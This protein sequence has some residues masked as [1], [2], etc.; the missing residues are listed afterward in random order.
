MHSRRVLR[1]EI[2]PRNR[3]ADDGDIA[4]VIS[5][6]APVVALEATPEVAALTAWE[7]TFWRLIYWIGIVW[8]H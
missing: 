4:D 5:S 3:H 2:R 8:L 7:T 6:R 1:L